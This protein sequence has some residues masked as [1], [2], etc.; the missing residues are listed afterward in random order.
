[1]PAALAEPAV[2]TQGASSCDRRPPPRSAA[3]VVGD[4]PSTFASTSSV[5]SP[6]SGPGPRT[7]AGVSDRRNPRAVDAHAC[8]PPAS[9]RRRSGRAR[10]AAGRA[11][12]GRRRRRRDPPPRRPPAGVPSRRRRRACASTPR[13]ARPARRRARTRPSRVA[14]RGSR[15]QSASPTT[16][17]KRRHSSSPN[18]V[19]AIQR[20]SPAHG[21]TPCGAPGPSCDALPTGVDGR[22]APRGRAAAVRAGS[23]PSPA[24]PGRSAGRRPVRRRCQSAASTASAP[25]LPAG[26]VGVRVAEAGGRPA[27]LAP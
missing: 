21:Y 2:A 26:E 15:V 20:S 14:K 9:G 24:A 7:A 16:P 4:S 13:R 5:C 12:T 27:G 17:A 19:I 11:R 6:S 8:G 1:M 25:R 23:R 10:R 18:T 3:I 22:R